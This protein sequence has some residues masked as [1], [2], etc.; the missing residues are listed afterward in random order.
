MRRVLLWFKQDLRLDDHPALQAARGAGA[1]LPVY[2]L[3]PAQLQPGP[4][5]SRGIGVH[6]ARFLLESLAALD[7]ALRQRGSQLLVLSGRAEQLIPQLVERFNLQ[8]VLTLEEIAP[9][10]CQQLQQL[11]AQL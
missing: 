7:G 3:D 11:R 6:R 5:G 1:L 4:L 9:H 8:E 2:I 10:E